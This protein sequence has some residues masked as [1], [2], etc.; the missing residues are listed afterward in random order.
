MATRRIKVPTTV[1]FRKDQAKTL[2]SFVEGTDLCEAQVV[3]LA[4]DDF[5]AR[6]PTM[7]P[8]AYVSIK[9][10]MKKYDDEHK[11]RTEKQK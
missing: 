1:Y 3:R 5:F 4:I 9:K 7:Q 10:R 2:K 11:T 8:G 6:Y